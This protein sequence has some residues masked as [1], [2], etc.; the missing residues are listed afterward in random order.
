MSLP[1][2]WSII[3]VFILLIILLL[4]VY[5]LKTR[6]RWKKQANKL[7]D[8]VQNLRF[9]LSSSPG[10]KVD[11][12]D[13]ISEIKEK[14]TSRQFEVFIHTI[15]GLSSKEIAA[16]LNLAPITIDSHIKEIVKNLNVKKR[17]QLSGVFFGKLK[18]KIGLESISDI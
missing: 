16:K 1:L 13:A 7:E 5:E 8:E 12:N 2:N 4:V 9:R 6:V 11:F 17:S 14:L 3:F 18:D 15:E 10:I